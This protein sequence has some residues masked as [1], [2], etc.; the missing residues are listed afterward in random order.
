MSTHLIELDI[1]R[2]PF[3]SRFKSI[4]FDGYLVIKVLGVN[5]AKSRSVTTINAGLT[6]KPKTQHTT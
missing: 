5:K 1:Q 3:S 2:F 4:L 6:L